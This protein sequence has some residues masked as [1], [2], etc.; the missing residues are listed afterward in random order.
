MKLYKYR[1]IDDLWLTLDIILN[2]RLWCA[3]WDTLNDPLEGRYEILFSPQSP[4]FYDIVNNKRD[5][6]RICSLSKS[7]DNFLLW[8]HYSSGHKGI[9]IEIDIAEEHPDLCKVNYQPFS[10]IF[11]EISQSHEDLRYLFQSKTEEWKY[12]KEYRIINENKYF[13][14]D[15]PIKRIF[16]G[17][18]VSEERFNILRSILPAEVKLIKMELDI[19][20]ARVVEKNA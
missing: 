11:T 3:K 6:L 10:P 16:I 4:K 13:Y 18:K 12:E 1:S 20:Q 8:S 19:T 2:K 9:A 7:L 5:C 15:K 17:P 14:I